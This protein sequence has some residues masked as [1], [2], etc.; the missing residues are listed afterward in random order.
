MILFEVL[1][2][3]PPNQLNMWQLYHFKSLP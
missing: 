3:N 2:Q 1:G